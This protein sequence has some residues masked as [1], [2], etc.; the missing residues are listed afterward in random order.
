MCEINS[1]P[2]F[3][4]ALTPPARVERDEN[5]GVRKERRKLLNS[6]VITFLP[7]LEELCWLVDLAVSRP[8]LPGPIQQASGAITLELTKNIDVALEGKV[9]VAE[10]DLSV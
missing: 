9:I 4:A 10:G 7:R 5:G 6:K 8:P 3:H 1:P 2:R